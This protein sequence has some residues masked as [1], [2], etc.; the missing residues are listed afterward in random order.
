VSRKAAI[1]KT[2]LIAFIQLPTLS[3]QE[4][5]GIFPM[6]KGSIKLRDKTETVI[7]YACAE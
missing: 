1:D 4:L 5:Y 6:I 7:F 2:I 3:G